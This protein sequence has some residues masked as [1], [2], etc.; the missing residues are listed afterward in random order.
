MS[1][2]TQLHPAQWVDLDQR[3]DDLFDACRVSSNHPSDC[4]T[5]RDRVRSK[6]TFARRMINLYTRPSDDEVWPQLA[7]WVAKTFDGPYADHV[8]NVLAERLWRLIKMVRR[9]EENNRGE[10]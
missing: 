10:G 3:F 2:V 1:N 9:L 6:C 7:S 4:Y 5:L 8:C